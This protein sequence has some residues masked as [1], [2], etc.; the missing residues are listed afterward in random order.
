MKEACS[1][2][3]L[4][5]IKGQHMASHVQVHASTPRVGMV[6]SVDGKINT[7]SV[8]AGVVY[9]SAPVSTHNSRAYF[10][11]LVAE[12]GDCLLGV[13]SWDSLFLSAPISEPIWALCIT[14]SFLSDSVN[15]EADNSPR[16]EGQETGVTDSSSVGVVV[17]LTCPE[18]VLS[19][20]TITM[21]VWDWSHPNT[22]ISQKEMKN[23]TCWAIT[24]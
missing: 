17:D 24:C 21:T 14:S 4:L 2:V 9:T 5:S 18:G 7:V 3:G 15:I 10:L 8:F 20:V 11:G 6:D 12:A 13:F 22:C 16:L 19:C 23:V 1:R